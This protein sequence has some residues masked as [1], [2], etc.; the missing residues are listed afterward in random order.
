MKLPF[1][2]R[3]RELRELDTAAER[4]G[5]LVVYGRRRIGKT[6][7]L[8]QW[9]ETRDGM[10]S[11]AIEAQRDQQIEQVFLDL[12]PHLG[13][14]LVPRTWRELFAILGLQ[15]PRG[16]CASTNSPT[17]RRLTVRCQPAAEMAR[18]RHPGRL[19]ADPGGIEHANDARLVS[20]SRGP[21]LRARPEIAACRSD[22]L[23]GVLPGVRPRRRTMASFEN[24]SC[25]GGIPPL[26]G[27]RRTRPGR[28][29]ARRRPYFDSAPYMEQEPQ[30]ILRD[31]GVAGLNPLAVLEAVGRGAERPSEI[32]SRLGTPQ[33]NLS[34][35]LQ[36]LLDTSVLVRDLPF[37]ESVRSTKKTLYQIQDPTIRFWFRV[38][39]PHRSRWTT[40][41]VAQRPGAGAR[42]CVDGLRGLLPGAVPWGRTALGGTHGTRPRRA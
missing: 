10:Y 29:G 13:T 20:Q 16:C 22:G 3:E 18:P 23:R 37:G 17:S 4:G 40:L 38:Y 31:E 32:A 9:L 12:Q 15:R 5:L 21:T 8:R 39:S 11:Q 27:V 33:S 41:S 30:R 28:A 2:N 25:V 1:V 42:A 19:P 6:R 26:L 7:L 34:R 14:A 24:F 36:L 35:L